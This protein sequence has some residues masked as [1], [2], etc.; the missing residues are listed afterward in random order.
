MIILKFTNSKFAK[1]RRE[2]RNNN[3]DIERYKKKNSGL[4]EGIKKKYKNYI[5][6]LSKRNTKKKLKKKSS[7]V[8]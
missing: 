3:L 2:K 5:I 4:G 7:L 8:C 1:K 6:K